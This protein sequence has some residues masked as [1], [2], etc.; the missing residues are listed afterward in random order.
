ME[1]EPSAVTLDTACDTI[2]EQHLRAGERWRRR[3]ESEAVLQ[4]LQALVEEAELRNLSSDR[5]VPDEMWRRLERLAE[6]V[7]VDPPRDLWR[8]QMTPRLH[9]ALLRWQGSLLDRIV[10]HR[11]EFSDRFD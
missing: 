8:A 11:V 1:G 5:Q 3:E 10:P 7:P 4:S 2:R 6:R 9:D